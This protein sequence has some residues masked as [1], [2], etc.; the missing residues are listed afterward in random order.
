MKDTQK[1]QIVPS[2]REKS[3]R[4]TDP[5]PL[6]EDLKEESRLRPLALREFVGQNAIRE[7]LLI[8]LEAA[9]R[10]NEAMD[11]VLLHGPP[12]LGKTTLA[13]IIAHE[14]GVEISQSSG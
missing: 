8:F 12:G 13:A 4:M 6:A 1:A 7:Q 5:E 14:L 3:G 11:H 2:A 10:R 9:K